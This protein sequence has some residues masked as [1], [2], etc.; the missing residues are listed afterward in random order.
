V[1]T[2]R[3]HGHLREKFGPEYQL[4]VRTPREAAYAL[5][6]VLPGFRDHVLAHNLPGY[7]VFVGKEARPRDLLDMPSSDREI[8]RIV[9]V[10]EGAGNTLKSIA[11]IIVGAALVFFSY[12][13]YAAAWAG[14]L[15]AGGAA[16]AIGGAVG[17]VGWGLALGGISTLLYSAPKQQFAHET[18][19]PENKP[20]YIFDGPVNTTRQGNCVPVLYGRLEIGSQVI[21]AGLRSYAITP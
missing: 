1:K 10:I 5:T 6:R 20:S 18:E 19:R 16:G 13:G 4:D 11:T 15:G 8:I 14:A 9:P 3:L 2:I 17:A 21:S 12:G 7:R